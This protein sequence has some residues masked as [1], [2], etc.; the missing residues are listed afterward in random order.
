MSLR[1]C[2][3]HSLVA[4]V[5]GT[6]TRVALALGPAVL[7]DSVRKY[8]NADHPDLASLLG[9]HL[10]TAGRVACAMACVAVAGPVADDV[11]E[12]TNFDWRIDA[13]GLPGP[14]ERERPYS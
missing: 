1:P 13:S 8:R 14:P 9:H 7:S 5:G 10:A 12:L 3:M 11:A 4:D 2:D 6:N